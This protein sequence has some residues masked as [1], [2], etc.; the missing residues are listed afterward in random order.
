MKFFS[1]LWLWM[2]LSEFKSTG[3]ISGYIGR[4]I[5]I[6]CSHHWASTNI[7]YFCRD[8]CGDRDVLVK[9]DRSPEG[10]YRLEDFGTG[11]FNVTI[12]E[13]QE[14]DSGI[15]RCGVQRVG[16]DTY[17][18]VNLIVQKDN[19]KNLE[20]V[21]HLRTMETQT[22][23]TAEIQ[24]TTPRHSFPISSTTKQG[25]HSLTSTVPV[26]FILYGA[27][28][29]VVMLIIFAV[30]LVSCQ[31]RKRVKKSRRVT[32]R[33]THN[34]RHSEEA[35]GVYENAPDD[36]PYA[37]IKKSSIKSNDMSQSDPIYQNLH[38]NT[39]QGDDIYGNL[40]IY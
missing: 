36:R 34:D 30:G 12:T 23:T 18:K 22:G 15:Y 7:K 6:K 39:S 1:V 37:T 33:S 3:G 17:Q 5:T 27:A 11:T 8:P 14:S 38:F 35:I 29:L 20:E 40:R 28:G 10:R 24:A 16:I 4:H 9:S 21:T 32:V 2:F 26:Y 13:L 19:T 25:T 31:W